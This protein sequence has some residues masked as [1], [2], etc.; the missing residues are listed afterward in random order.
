VV[1]IANG[2]GVINAIKGA[3][4]V[5]L[6]ILIS[7]KGTGNRQEGLRNLLNALSGIMEDIRSHLNTFS[8]FFTRYVDE[9]E[10]DSINATLTNLRKNLKPEE[11]S[12]ENLV[13]L[14]EDMIRKTEKGP[15]VIDPIRGKPGPILKKF[16]LT[17]NSKSAIEA[18]VNKHQKSIST[19]LARSDYQLA[20][21]KLKELRQLSEMLG[22][23]YISDIYNQSA[24]DFI[25]HL[26]E[27]LRSIATRLDQ[28]NVG[29]NP[30]DDCDKLIKASVDIT[31]NLQQ[32]IRN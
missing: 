17:Q 9:K 24:T 18:Q 27:E 4:S 1:D 23:E 25:N 29:K 28:C 30:E 21:Y 5:K 12:N 19:S 3:R 14:L 22:Y 26:K 11:E 7:S 32:I 13:A 31:S 8:Y 15:I 10:R 16:V 20:I 6:V 2:L